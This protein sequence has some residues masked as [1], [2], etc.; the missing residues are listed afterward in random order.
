[1]KSNHDIFHGALFS[2]IKFAGAFEGQNVTIFSPDNKAFETSNFDYKSVPIPELRRILMRHIV[3]GIVMLK[4]LKS[5]P[6][7]LSISY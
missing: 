2:S 3:K 7:S 1:M 6:V 5:G 4:D